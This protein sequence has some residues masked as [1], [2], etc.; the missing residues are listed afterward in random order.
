MTCNNNQY[1]LKIFPK[2]KIGV[3]SVAGGGIGLFANEFIPKRSIIIPYCGEAI[4][5]FLE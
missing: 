4:E 2:L 5:N 1:Q 3:S